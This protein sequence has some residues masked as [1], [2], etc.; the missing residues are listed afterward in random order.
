MAA[1]QVCG[2][3]ALYL[4]S[5]PQAD[6]VD[7]RNWIATHGS[8]EVPNTDATS[9]TA[10]FYD[11]YQSNSATDEDYWGNTYSLKSASRRILYNPFCSDGKASLD[12]VELTGVVISYK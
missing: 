6:R 12:G 11:P 7:V 9:E 2:V 3:V 10:G 4:Q 8:T 5:Q 1:P